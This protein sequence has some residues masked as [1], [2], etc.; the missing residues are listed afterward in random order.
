MKPH[1]LGLL[2]QNLIS[3]IFDKANQSNVILRNIQGAIASQT[4]FYFDG[5][6]E[7]FKLT[8]KTLIEKQILL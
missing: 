2:F 8:F 5:G 3:I 7:P 1:Y 4:T 6:P